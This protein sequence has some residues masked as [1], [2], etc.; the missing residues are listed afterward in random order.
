M[1]KNDVEIVDVF[2]SQEEA[3]LGHEYQFIMDTPQAEN[4]FN[5]LIEFLADTSKK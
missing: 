5:Q 1:N 2:Y 4:T 3:E